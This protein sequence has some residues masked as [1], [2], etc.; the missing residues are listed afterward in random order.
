LSLHHWF[1]EDVILK[2]PNAVAWSFDVTLIPLVVASGSACVGARLAGFWIAAAKGM[3]CPD[4]EAIREYPGNGFDVDAIS[5]VLIVYYG[6]GKVFRCGALC[7]TVWSDPN[8]GWLNPI[9]EARFWTGKRAVSGC[10]I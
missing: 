4:P 9:L 6:T 8:F 5:S 10:D 7:L 1:I 2:N 3:I